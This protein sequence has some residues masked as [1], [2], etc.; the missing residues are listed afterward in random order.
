MSD[1]V[2][3][4]MS[5]SSVV[6]SVPPDRIGF[7]KFIVEAYDNLAILSTVDAGKGEVVLRFPSGCE[8]DVFAL[9]ESLGAVIFHPPEPC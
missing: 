8:D 7:C 1:Q 3:V 4:R 2:Y 9:L 5:L 6:A